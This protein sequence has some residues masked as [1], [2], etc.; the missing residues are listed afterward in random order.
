[1]SVCRSEGWSVLVFVCV[2]VCSF[3]F[4]PNSSLE[5]HIGNMIRRKIFEDIWN[6]EW[7]NWS[8]IFYSA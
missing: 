5:H 8:S 6:V 2:S 7:Y 4:V 1:M 3:V